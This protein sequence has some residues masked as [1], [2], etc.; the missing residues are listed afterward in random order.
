MTVREAG[1]LGGKKVQEARDLRDRK[2]VR[3]HA[4]DKPGPAKGEAFGIAAITQAL[5]GVDFPASKDDL[6]RR[7]GNKEIEYRKGQ[8]VSLR[9]ILE[10]LDMDEFPSMANVVP[11]D[12][13]GLLL[14]R[15]RVF[16]AMF[17][18]A[19][20]LSRFGRFRILERLGAG[21]M[22]RAA[23]RPMHRN[24]RATRSRR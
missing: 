9:D 21:A 15:A 3:H 22:G 16:A 23:R 7:A 13:A 10:D 24:L 12:S 18:E 5:S 20:E 6:L 2:E 19:S 17:G 14:S 11:G 8:P 1:H 4:Y